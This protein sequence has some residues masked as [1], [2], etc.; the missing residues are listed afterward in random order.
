MLLKAPLFLDNMKGVF[1]LKVLTRLIMVGCTAF[2]IGV[3]GSAH[4]QYVGPGQGAGLTTVAEILKN[5]VDDQ[6]V[7]LRG[8]ITRKLK[9][10][11]Y[12]FRD[13]TGA[14][15]VEIDDKYFYNLK[16]TDKTV[17]EIY[18]EVE[19]EFMKSP[20]IDVKR[21]TIIQP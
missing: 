9:K 17:V 8:K 3:L 18:G 20:E 14:I 7:L 16:V 11:R 10:E 19:K 6:E 12:E 21:L 1:M 4:A 2:A 5:P 13:D 15:R